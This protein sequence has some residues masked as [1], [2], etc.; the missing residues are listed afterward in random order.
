MYNYSK[1]QLRQKGIYKI[2]FSHS[3]KCYIGSTVNQ[4]GF[5]GRWGQH[6]HDLKKEKHHNKYL[7]NLYNKYGETQI[8]FEIVEVMDSECTSCVLEKE[9]YYITSYNSYK[10]GYNLSEYADDSRRILQVVEKMRIPIL[11]YNLDGN[12]I[13]EWE[14]MDEVKDKLCTTGL[15]EVIDKQTTAC[16]FQ[17]RLK[18]KDYPLFIG[19][20]YNCQSDRLLCYTLDGNFY[21]EYLSLLDAGKD[22]S[23]NHGSIARHISGGTR[24]VKEYVFK[25]YEENYPLKINPVCRQH[26]FQFPVKITDVDN[27]EEWIFYSLRESEDFG[28]ARSTIKRYFKKQVPFITKYFKGRKFKAEKITYQNYLNYKY[29]KI[30]T[31]Q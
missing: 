7:Q 8:I 1:Q 4:R 31:N 19:Q 21:K 23:L 24:Y 2:R 25:Y 10:N 20:Y 28:F 26:T 29:A 16:G 22:L 27:S 13:R 11:Q 5:K 14:S 15:R 30:E 9:E 3:E 17:W 6:L 12:F 18:T